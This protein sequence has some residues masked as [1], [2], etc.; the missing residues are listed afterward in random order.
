MR[1]RGE[2]QAAVQLTLEV[3]HVIDVF[4]LSSALFECREMGDL[5][6][7][8]PLLIWIHVIARTRRDRTMDLIDDL[9]I[10]VTKSEFSGRL[11]PEAEEQRQSQSLAIVGHA[12]R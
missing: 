2:N 11:M 10:H 1:F 5:L 7:N 12:A 3:R 8:D 6:A 9:C 4:C